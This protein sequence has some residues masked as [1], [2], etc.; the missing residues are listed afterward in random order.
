MNVEPNAPFYP[1]VMTAADLETPAIDRRERYR[2]IIGYAQSSIGSRAVSEAAV[3]FDRG[4]RHS[5]EEVNL[6]KGRE[7]EAR[8]E[9]ENWRWR[10]WLAVSVALFWFTWAGIATTIAIGAITR[11]WR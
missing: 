8:A 7:E 11:L 4:I 3:D 9:S 10:F 2:K 5:I 1:P 6:W